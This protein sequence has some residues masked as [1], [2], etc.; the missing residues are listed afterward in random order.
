M[1]MN[2]LLT[3]KVYPFYLIWVESGKLGQRVN[4]D[5]DIVSF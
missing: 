1:K 5:S 2:E 4:S 3:Q